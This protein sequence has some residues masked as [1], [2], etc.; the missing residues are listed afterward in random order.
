MPRAVRQTVLKIRS[1]MPGM[2][3]PPQQNK[4][5]RAP[6]GFGQRIE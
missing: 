3:A 4:S 2:L 5:H 1:Q 6:P